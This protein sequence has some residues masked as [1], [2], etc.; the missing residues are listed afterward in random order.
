MRSNWF[1]RIFVL[2]VLACGV[3]AVAQDSSLTNITGSGTKGKIPLFTGTNKIGNSKITQDGSGNEHFGA[4]ITAKGVIS[5][6]SDVDA[7]GNV[8]ASGGVTAGGVISGSSDVDL[9]GNVNATG[10]V[11][12]EDF[13]ESAAGVYGG[14]GS[15]GATF[16]G[17]GAFQPSSSAAIISSTADGTQVVQGQ[18]FFNGGF[19]FAFYDLN[20]NAVFY[21]DSVGDTVAIGSKSAAV[22]LKSGKMV[23]VYSQESTQVWFEDF[24]SAQLVG[25]VATVKLDSKFSQLVNTKQPYHVFLTPNGDCHGLYVTQKEQNSFEVRELGGGQS[26]VAFDYRISALRNGYEKVRLEPAIMPTLSKTPQRPQTPKK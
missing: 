7:G 1:L 22:P 23:K 26:S 10:Y 24:G 2:F 15:F 12:S 13:V 19:E 17:Q 5:G 14:F 11:F 20:S 18:Q 21:G 3:S 9:L 8:N 6:L 16:S 4:G 25:G